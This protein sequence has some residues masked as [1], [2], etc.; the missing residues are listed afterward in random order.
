MLAVNNRLLT[1][2]EYFDFSLG[3]I[4]RSFRGLPGLCLV[5]QRKT[6]RSGTTPYECAEWKVPARLTHDLK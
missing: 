3:P 6:R 1:V 4:D 2:P 5:K